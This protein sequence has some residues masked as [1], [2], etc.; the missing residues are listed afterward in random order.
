M[1]VKRFFAP[2]MRQAMKL[3]RDEFGADAAIL[4]NNKV[5]GGVE[6]VTAVDY[7]ASILREPS[8]R[9]D[10]ENSDALTDSL[11]GALAKAKDVIESASGGQS[12]ERL[13][14]AFQAKAKERQFDQAEALVDTLEPKTRRQSPEDA[15]MRAMQ[16]EIQGLRELLRE[17]MKDSIAE[18]KPVEAMMYKRLRRMGLS[19]H[20]SAR[21]VEGADLS[22]DAEFSSAWDEAV[23]Q[24]RA[25]IL[26]TGSDVVDQGGIVALMGP[27]GVGKT[28]TIGKLAARYVLKYGPDSLA[29]VTTDCYRVAA[30]EQLRTFGRILGVP[31]RVV[32]EKNTLDATLKSLKSK[33]LVLID[34]A[35]LSVKDPN[36]QEQFSLLETASVRIRKY[37]VFSAT[38]QQQVLQATYDTYR[39]HGLNGC[40]V[41]KLD[42]ASS[43][44][45]VISLIADNRL[46]LAYLSSG[47]KI[48]DDLRVGDSGALLSKALELLERAET[49]EAP[50]R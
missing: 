31:V 6:I 25:G 44:G 46:P 4:S 20:F 18:R 36:M 15:A 37:L 24:V 48:P 13:E 27:T 9:I 26:T 10:P 28:T 5:A 8:E 23:E 34:T 22:E 39:N 45:E 47:Q 19:E 32:D 42:E 43:G 1:K 35:G 3:V 7:D 38:S 2:D 50:D 14:N 33:A 30:Y 16:S 41:T 29:L 21:I 17:Q 49:N 40:V 11:A 12:P